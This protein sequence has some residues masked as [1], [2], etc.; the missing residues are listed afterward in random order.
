MNVVLPPRNGLSLC[1]GGGG[2]DMGLML[3][4]PDFHTRCYVEWEAEPRKR[5]IAAQLAGYFA[6]APIWDDVTSFDGKPLRGAVDTILAGYPCQPFSQAGKRKGAADERHLW[7]D[8]ARII[9]EVQPAWVILENVAGHVTL[10]SE[11]VL[12]EL[13]DMGFATTASLH[14]A[15]ETGTPHERLR[16]FCVSYSKSNARRGRTGLARGGS[17]F[18]DANKERLQGKLREKHNQ[19]RRAKQNVAIRYSS[20]ARIH[21][22]GPAQSS[23]WSDVFRDTPDLAPALSRSGVVQASQAIV[24]RILATNPKAYA[25]SDCPSAPGQTPALRLD[26]QAREILAVSAAEPAIRRMVDGLAQR[27]HALKLLG[28][29]VHP[30]GAAN[31]LRTLF[32]THGLGRFYVAGTENLTRNEAREFV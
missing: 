11:T 22:P 18:P 27:S 7:P 13:Q 9:R 30:L 29:G 6:P 25:Q 10:G 5:I 26:R 17:K 32:S 2:L 20:G 1:A 14:S 15:G 3:T 19:K 21:P 16:W 23:E 8:I 28:N 4:E 24:A 31:A 12:R